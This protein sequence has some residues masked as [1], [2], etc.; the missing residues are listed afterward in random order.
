MGLG[1]INK[2]ENDLTQAQN[3][4]GMEAGQQKQ[5]M[6]DQ[7]AQANFAQANS[8][9]H[10]AAIQAGLIQHQVDI[11]AGNQQE[12]Y[13]SAGVVSNQ[14]TPLQEVNST[15]AYGAIQVQAA[16]DHGAAQAALFRTQGQLDQEGGL[17]DLLS[18]EGQ[19]VINNDQ[20]KLQQAQ[21]SH[22]ELM[23]FLGMG[24]GLLSAGLGALKF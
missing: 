18:A 10:D 14:G 12:E 15:R 16:L 20:N 5:A 4:F 23:G 24:T 21:Q 22:Q 11:Y 8:A 2:S 17:Q 9:I 1:G 6:A 19:S 13:A 7:E 3:S